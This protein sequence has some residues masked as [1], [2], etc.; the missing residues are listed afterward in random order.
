LSHS[1]FWR[2]LA[3]VGGDPVGYAIDRIARRSATPSTWP[4]GVDGVGDR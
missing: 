4:I 1:N 2:A 3:W